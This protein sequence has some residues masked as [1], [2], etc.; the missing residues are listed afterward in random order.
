MEGRGVVVEL[1]EFRILLPFRFRIAS[2]YT[3][4]H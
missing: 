4:G 1:V 2:M 3:D